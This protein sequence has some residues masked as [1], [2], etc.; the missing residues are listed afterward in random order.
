MSSKHTSTLSAPESLIQLQSLD[1]S[2]HDR[3]GCSASLSHSL[4]DS[5]LTMMTR[6]V[7]TKPI[8]FLPSTQ[9]AAAA[10]Y[11]QSQP[12]AVSTLHSI[13][14]STPTPCLLSFSFNSSELPG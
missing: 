1:S 8:W 12:V 6:L 4:P 7:H 14:K 10:H 3:A 9:R 13:V 11:L 5:T 2:T